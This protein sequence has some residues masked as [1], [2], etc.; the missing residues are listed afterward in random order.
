MS[1]VGCLMGMF[2][3]VADADDEYAI[4]RDEL[5]HELQG[6]GTVARHAHLR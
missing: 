4:D 6:R 2:H 5:L 3:T 1:C